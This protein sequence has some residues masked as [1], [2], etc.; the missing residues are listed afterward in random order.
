MFVTT[1]DRER[2]IGVLYRV[3][4]GRAE[5]FAGGTPDKGAAAVLK[6]P[7]G[8][9]VDAGGVYVADRMQGAV[10]KLDA[11]GRV[12]RERYVEVTRPRLMAADEWVG[13]GSEPTAPPMRRGNRPRAR[14]GASARTARLGRCCAVHWPRPLP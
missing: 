6:Q 14:S 10:L 2:K 7:E 5:L 4:D 9:V 11:A 3:V 1:F 12:V 13:S 8:A